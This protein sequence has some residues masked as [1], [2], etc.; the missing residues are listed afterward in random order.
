M[1]NSNSITVTICEFEEFNKNFNINVNNLNTKTINNQR[2]VLVNDRSI[3]LFIFIFLD[4]QSEIQNFS[5]E[6]LIDCRLQNFN[7]IMYAAYLNRDRII[8]IIINETK[9]RT[10]FNRYNDLS[11][12]PFDLALDFA[13]KN[14]NYLK[15][16]FFSVQILYPYSNIND[17]MREVLIF[18]IF[19][20]LKSKKE[21]SNEISKYKN[22]FLYFSDTN[23]ATNLLFIKSRE[24]RDRGYEYLCAL[25]IEKNNSNKSN[26]M[27]S[28]ELTKYCSIDDVVDINGNLFEREF[29][30]QKI[31]GRQKYST[32][33]ECYKS[34]KNSDNYYYYLDSVFKIIYLLS[35][36]ELKSIIIINNE[37]PDEKIQ[38]ILDFREK[39]IINST[40]N[41]TYEN[42]L[43]YNSEITYLIDDNNDNNNN[44][45]NINI[46]NFTYD[47]S[48][49][50]Y[51]N[52]N[53]TV[54]ESNYISN[55]P[56]EDI[57]II[58]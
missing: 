23:L 48:S 10:I 55:Y 14:N 30:E 12:S 18:R 13:T 32:L 31:A 16:F 57:T 2:C 34:L 53:Q 39:C 33:N 7:P 49:S 25:F 44:N 3:K 56:T 47:Q 45:I 58:P 8:R 40:F 28:S 20:Y 22:K 1:E 43:E 41:T 9:T 15:Q 51:F 6:E 42:Y 4:K 37:L 27:N 38:K 21:I 46:H 19:N 50:E 36:D 29:Y 24:S 11:L 26:N 35:E 17:N 5:K 52:H 54:I